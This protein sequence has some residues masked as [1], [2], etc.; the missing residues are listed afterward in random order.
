[1]NAIFM[2]LKG[3]TLKPDIGKHPLDCSRHL[4]DA[5]LIN[6]RAI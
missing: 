6:Y 5:R 3:V 1:M 4:Y 2:M